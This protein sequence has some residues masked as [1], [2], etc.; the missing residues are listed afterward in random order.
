M[1]NVHNDPPFYKNEISLRQHFVDIIEG[2]PLLICPILRHKFRVFPVFT[3]PDDILKP[4]FFHLIDCGDRVVIRLCFLCRPAE[5]L[6]QRPGQALRDF[7]DRKS[8]V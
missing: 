6:L 1:E 7:L 3:D 8:V 4:E 5:E 2:Q